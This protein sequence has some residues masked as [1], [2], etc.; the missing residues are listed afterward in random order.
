MWK[1]VC[2]NIVQ[3]AKQMYGIIIYVKLNVYVLLY[4]QEN[5]WED[6]RSH[7]ESKRLS[8]TYFP[9]LGSWG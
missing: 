8:T 1:G 7:K 6:V 5:I 3:A 4:T 2:C 9:P